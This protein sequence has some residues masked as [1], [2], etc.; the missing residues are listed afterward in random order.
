MF[1]WPTV[2]K[3]NR[4]L[5]PTASPLNS[6]VAPFTT[7]ITKETPKICGAALGLLVTEVLLEAL[8]FAALFVRS[9]INQ[10]PIRTD[11][12]R[13]SYAVDD[14]N[15]HLMTSSSRLNIIKF[16]NFTLKALLAAFL[17]RSLSEVLMFTNEIIVETNKDVFWVSENKFS[18]K[19]WNEFQGRGISYSFLLFSMIMA[20]RIFYLMFKNTAKW[21]VYKVSFDK[22]EGI[23]NLIS[24]LKVCFIKMFRWKAS[25]S[26]LI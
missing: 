6:S 17:S 16:N 22:R 2:W 5:C 7:E 3:D 13:K 26:F 20:T 14:T 21:N 9:P 10:F 15:Y 1:L 12:L 8:V 4:Y 23:H 24:H 25:E 11:G 19:I 18:T